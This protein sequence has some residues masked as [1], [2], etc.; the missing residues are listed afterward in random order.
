MSPPDFAARLAPSDAIGLAID[1]A[2]DAVVERP[3][4]DAPTSPAGPFEEEN[5]KALYTR[6]GGGGVTSPAS[7]RGSDA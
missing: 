5:K 3:H 2:T 4:A 6:S 7:S 1:V